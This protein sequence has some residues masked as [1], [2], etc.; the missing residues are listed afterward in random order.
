MKFVVRRAV[1]GFL[2]VPLVAGVYTLFFTWL[3]LAGGEPN[4]TPEQVFKNGIG[5]GVV[6]AVMLV[7]APQLG[8]FL[9]RVVGE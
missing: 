6:V 8:K 7:F 5:L 4:A 9:T 3:V 2:S 1:V